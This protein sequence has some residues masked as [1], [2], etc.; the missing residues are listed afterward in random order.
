[1]EA[2]RSACG[3]AVVLEGLRNLFSLRVTPYSDQKASIPLGDAL[4]NNWF[5]LWYQPKI[6]LKTLH[7]V[8]AEAL[9]RALHPSRG[10]VA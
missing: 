8:G 1:M 7:L 3:T 10:I 9:V 5:E 2:R 6:E 4:K